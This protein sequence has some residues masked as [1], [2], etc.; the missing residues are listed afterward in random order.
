MNQTI[1]MKTSNSSMKIPSV[2]HVTRQEVWR[3]LQPVPEPKPH[4][5]LAPR[6]GRDS[7]KRI[8]TG[9]YLRRYM[10]L[11]KLLKPWSDRFREKYNRTPTL[12]DV[13]D[14]NIPGLLERFIEYLDTL[15]ALR[16]E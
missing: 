4:E 1:I 14:A 7:Q 13:H 3:F 5:I 6:R 8:R 16:L 9:E 2:P 15:D 11:R 12:V 10:Y